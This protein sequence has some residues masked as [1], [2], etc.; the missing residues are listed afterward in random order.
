MTRPSRALHCSSRA[1]DSSG[2][3]P[4]SSTT[5]AT[6]ASVSAGSTGSPARSDGHSIARCSS[7]RRIGPTSTW[8]APTS[9]ASPL[10]RGA[11]PVEVGAHRKDDLAVVLDQRVQEGG[12]LGGVA[13][14]REDLLELV[15]HEQ[16][17]IL[18]TRVLA[19]SDDPHR[20][21]I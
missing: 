19:G 11:A 12:P 6:S 2:R 7:S 14:D 10:V 15:D 16:V 13:T 20:P 1:A 21:A 9:R 8:W 17:R 18:G 4:G 5:S 3:L